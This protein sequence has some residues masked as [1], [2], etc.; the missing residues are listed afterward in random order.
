MTGVSVAHKPSARGQRVRN[1]HPDGGSIGEGNSP[2]N[3]DFEIGRC[4]SATGIDFS[5][6]S[7]Y[8]CAGL[9]YRCSGAATS[10]MRP[11]YITMTRSLTLF[12]TARSWAMKIS[13]RLNV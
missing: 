7:V 3:A 2:A 4:G 13:V 9:A 11:R 6:A 12:T 8:G 5:S 1:R 10:Q